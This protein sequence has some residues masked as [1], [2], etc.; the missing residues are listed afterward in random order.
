MENKELTDTLNQL[1]ETVTVI[2]LLKTLSKLCEE[3]SNLNTIDSFD[4]MTWLNDANTI[5]KMTRFI[6]N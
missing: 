5:N 6:N 4:Q 2:E 3:K 1:L